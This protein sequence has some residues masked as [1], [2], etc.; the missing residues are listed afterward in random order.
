MSNSG[1][2]N[3]AS[4][5]LVMPV[6]SPA[7]G[8]IGPSA[9]DEHWGTTHGWRR[10][11]AI[12]CWVSFPLLHMCIAL[13]FAVYVLLMLGSSI[14]WACWI[15]VTRL[16][17]RMCG[18]IPAETRTWMNDSDI[19]LRYAFLVSGC[20][21]CWYLRRMILCSRNTEGEYNLACGYDSA[22]CWSG[23]NLQGIRRS[24]A[25]PNA[26]SGS[27]FAIF[28]AEPDCTGLPHH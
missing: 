10:R 13:I 11:L 14:R 15:S 1:I 19:C 21:R 5:L 25:E 26:R 7:R 8:D 12:S 18:G 17:N 23:I 27:A 6:R 4:Q 2:M 16:S 22:G 20:R 28:P 3:F 24:N 9:L